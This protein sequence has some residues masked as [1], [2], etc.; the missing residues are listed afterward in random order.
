[1]NSGDYMFPFVMGLIL[2]AII[3]GCFM[4][5]ITTIKEFEAAEKFCESNNGFKEIKNYFLTQ[6]YVCKNG[7]VLTTKIS[8]DF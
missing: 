7:A 6:D 2:S 5:D 8:W 3:S 1:M 4:S